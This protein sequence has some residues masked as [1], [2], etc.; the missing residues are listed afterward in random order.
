M[1]VNYMV[2]S[3]AGTGDPIYGEKNPQ[4]CNHLPARH[5]QRVYKSAAYGPTKAALISLAE[6]LYFD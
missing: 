2:L 3:D 6:S 1:A 4:R 5:W